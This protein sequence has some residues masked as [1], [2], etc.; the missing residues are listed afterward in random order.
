MPS[1]C[2]QGENCEVVPPGTGPGAVESEVNFERK[3]HVCSD[4]HRERGWVETLGR[5]HGEPVRQRRRGH[6]PFIGPARG[7]EVE[8]VE[9]S[10]AIFEASPRTIGC[11]RRDV[12]CVLE[13]S[14][15]SEQD[16]ALAFS[17]DLEAGVK[18]GGDIS[19]GGV[20]E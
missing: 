8:M 11:Q 7:R 1:D 13:A 15:G 14:R 3:G 17:V 20:E 19:E 16:Q 18:T 12:N 4:V 9:G 5:R 2:G 10:R 6:G